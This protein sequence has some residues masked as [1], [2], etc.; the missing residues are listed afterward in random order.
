MA[1]RGSR[2]AQTQYVYAPLRGI[3]FLI[4][5][6]LF[7]TLADTVAKWLTVDTPTG[8]IIF[9]RGVSTL[10]CILFLVIRAGP[11]SLQLNNP[12]GTLERA[13]VAVVF[14]FFLMASLRE[15]PIAEVIA[16]LY[17]S[18]LILAAIAPTMLRETVGMHRWIAILIAFAGVLVMMRPGAE[19][20]YWV[21]LLPLAAAGTSAF[22]DV[23]TRRVAGTET[24]LA[25]QFYTTLAMIIFG[26]VTVVFGWRVLPWSDVGLLALCGVLQFVGQYFFIDAFRYASAT[27]L[28]P[29][30][31]AMLVWA[32]IV[33]FIVWGD[34]PDAWAIVGTLLIA[35]GGLY[36]I[37]RVP[38]S[39]DGGAT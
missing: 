7:L 37:Y 19:G 15:L 26:G 13:A 10:P 36:A 22:R 9:G 21:A 39:G 24:S 14:T 3:T 31:Y 23:L 16:I 12:R 27:T 4:L 28:A 17:A 32:L 6:G 35:G 34:V 33:G 1:S 38:A 20:L 5:G 8:E 29:F 25:I 2:L 18:P 11:R 30:R